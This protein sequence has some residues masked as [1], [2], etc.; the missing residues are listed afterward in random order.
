MLRSAGRVDYR[1]RATGTWT[2]WYAVG[3]IRERGTYARGRR[4]G[5]WTRWHVNGLK[6]SEGERSWNDEQRSSPR[7][8][9]W[10]FWYRNGQLRGVGSFET[11]RAVDD[12]TWWNHLGQLDEKRSGV[13]VD[14]VR[15]DD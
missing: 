11:G 3:E 14:G 12:W 6:H 10:T 8:G 5:T 4:A 9:P 7:E 1:G 15:R 13:Y 2:Y